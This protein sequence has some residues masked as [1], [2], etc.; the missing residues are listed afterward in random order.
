[1]QTL[2]QIT[3]TETI[4]PQKFFMNTQK[5]G[6]IDGK[7]FHATMNEKNQRCRWVVEGEDLTAGD[8]IKIAKYLWK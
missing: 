5:I 4:P 8:K 6:S 2:S 7:S 3:I 1:M